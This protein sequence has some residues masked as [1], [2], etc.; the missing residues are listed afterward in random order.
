MNDQTYHQFI[1]R[2]TRSLPQVKSA[3][4]ALFE[5]PESRIVDYAD[6]ALEDPDETLYYEYLPQ[7]SGFKI[8][9]NLYL[10]SAHWEAYFYTNVILDLAMKLAEKLDSDVAVALDEPLPDG[11]SDWTLVRPDGTV[12]HVKERYP[13]EDF[14]DVEMD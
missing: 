7:D 14:F 1:F 8:F 3:L 12:E 11:G 9:L 2:E 6:I 5:I 4:A 13:D 10:L